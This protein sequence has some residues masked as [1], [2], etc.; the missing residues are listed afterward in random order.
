MGTQ[1]GAY[2]TIAL[3]KLPYNPEKCS[4][5]ETREQIWVGWVGQ[6]K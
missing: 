2:L 3:L 6:E 4:N 1:A 5:P